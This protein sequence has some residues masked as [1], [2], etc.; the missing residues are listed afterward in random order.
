MTTLACVHHWVID[1]PNGKAKLQGKCV[2]CG[3]TR[4]WFASSYNPDFLEPRNA[5][6]HTNATD[7]ENIEIKIAVS[8]PRPSRW[9]V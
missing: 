5:F 1:S 8:E 6:K 3:D 4:E 2:L 7:P 9:K